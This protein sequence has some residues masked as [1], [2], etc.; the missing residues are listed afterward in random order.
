MLRRKTLR[1]AFGSII[2][3]KNRQGYVISLEA[4][5]TNPLDQSK[6][7]IKSFPLGAKAVAQHWFD[8]EEKL[9]DAHMA[10]IE[11]WTPP[12]VREEK[13][14]RQRHCSET[15]QNSF[16]TLT[17]PLTVLSS[18]RRRHKKA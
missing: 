4:R 6:R 18:S 12:K 11:T 10:G 13:R 5:Y 1:S 9:V 16:L 3:R 8:E 14:Q 17:V 7:V 15:T 2:Q